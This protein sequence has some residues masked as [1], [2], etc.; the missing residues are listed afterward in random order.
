M[1]KVIE[2]LVVIAACLFFLWPLNVLGIVV[3]AVVMG[4]IVLKDGEA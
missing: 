3:M 1:S 2:A 4:Y